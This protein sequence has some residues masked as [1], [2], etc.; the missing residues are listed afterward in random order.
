M[1]LL[2]LLVALV[3]GFAAGVAAIAVHRTLP[4]LLLGTATAVAVMVALRPWEP[5][6]SAAFA[7]GWLVPL[8]AAVAGRSEGDYAVAS[9]LLGWLLIGSGFVVLVTGITAAR[10][11]PPRRDAVESGDRPYHGRS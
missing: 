3:L 10:P 5:R 6:A 9:D 2:V 8:V 7:A 4:G 11:L 1:R